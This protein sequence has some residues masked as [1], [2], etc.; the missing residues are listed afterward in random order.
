MENQKLRLRITNMASLPDG[1][2]LEV[3]VEPGEILEVGRDTGIG[4]SLPDPRR[5]VSS[6]HMEL[7][8]ERVSGGS[9]I[10]RPT[11]RSSTEARHGSRALTR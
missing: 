7:R 9:T 6:R 5:F 1:G 10:F 11:E 8:H 2:P 3:S 4:W